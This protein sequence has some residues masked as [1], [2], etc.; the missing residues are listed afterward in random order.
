M[1][2]TPK[3][4]W[5]TWKSKNPDQIPDKFKQYSKEWQKIHPDYKYILL[6]DDDLRNIVKSVVPE[7]LNDYDNF[8]SVIERV[9][10]A[11]YALLYKYGGIYADM[12]ILPFKKMNVWTNKN[13]IVLG[14]EPKEHAEKIYGRDKVLCNAIMISPP[15]KKYWK[16]LMDSIISHYEHHQNPVFTTG[17]MAMTYLYEKSPEL[18]KDIIITDPCI[19]Y[20]MLGDGKISDN[21]N[22]AKSYVVHVWENTWTTDGI[23]SDLRWKNKRYWFFGLLILFLIGCIIYA[24]KR[25]N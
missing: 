3:I 14:C 17:P 11:R 19:F 13:V 9:D 23:F 20:P 18:H 10:F 16:D 2:K 1:S 21:C 7:Y 12:D 25:K 15:G 5:Q 24:W 22:L 6:D 8:T 4:I